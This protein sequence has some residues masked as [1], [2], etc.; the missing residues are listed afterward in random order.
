MAQVKNS[1]TWPKESG[2]KWIFS[3]GRIII[4]DDS[5]DE[6]EDDGELRRKASKYRMDESS[7]DDENHDGNVKKNTFSNVVS[8][9][10]FFFPHFVTYKYFYKSILPLF[11]KLETKKRKREGTSIATSRK[12]GG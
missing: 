2:Y 10:T 6:D 12:T 9:K 11:Y 4:K 8:Q 3:D 1:R 5:D 7:E